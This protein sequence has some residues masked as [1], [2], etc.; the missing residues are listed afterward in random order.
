MR[1]KAVGRYD[2]KTVE[3]PTV[4]PSYRR[5]VVSALKRIVGMPDYPAYLSHMAERHAGCPVLSE[6]EFFDQYVSARYGGGATR[7]C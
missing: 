2:G 4:V 1:D 3:E 5:T 6:R 7:C